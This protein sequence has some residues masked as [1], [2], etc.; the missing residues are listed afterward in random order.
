MFKP[1][2]VFSRAIGLLQNFIAMGLPE[3]I[4]FCLHRCGDC[5]SASAGRIQDFMMCPFWWGGLNSF[6]GLFIQFLPFL[7]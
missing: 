5:I 2:D 7:L 3:P 6:S 4:T 1:I